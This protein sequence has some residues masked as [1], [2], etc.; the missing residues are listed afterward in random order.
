[1]ILDLSKAQASFGGMLESF[2]LRYIG[3]IDVD[4][5]YEYGKNL[6]I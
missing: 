5:E 2:K 6:Y 3:E 1:L 4:D